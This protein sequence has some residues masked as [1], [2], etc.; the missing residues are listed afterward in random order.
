MKSRPPYEEIC[1]DSKLPAGDAGKPVKLI[2]ADCRNR[3]ESGKTPNPC[4]PFAAI[5]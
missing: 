1:K 4:G 3:F 2:V 5:P